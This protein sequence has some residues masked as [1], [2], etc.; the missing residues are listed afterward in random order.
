MDWAVISAIS[1]A[2]WTRISEIS[3]F[4]MA[5]VVFVGG[6]LSVLQ[7]RKLS[8]SGT[9]TAF[10][11]ILQW[12]QR[13]DI[14]QARRY[15]MST[16]KDKDYSKWIEYDKKK[17]EQVCST[18]D[19]AGVMAKKHLIKKYFVVDKWADSIVKC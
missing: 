16:L 10:T 19:V 2:D 17:A 4:F 12:L 11:D 5:L 3:T 15:L 1:T 13:E 8:R 9:A 18:Y 7:F 6:I 14:R